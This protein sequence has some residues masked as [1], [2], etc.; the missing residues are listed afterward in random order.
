MR[1]FTERAVT[2]ALFLIATLD[3]GAATIINSPVDIRAGIVTGTKLSNPLVYTGAASISTS[4]LRTITGFRQ[5]E[6]ADFTVVTVPDTGA[7][8]DDGRLDDMMDWVVA[9]KTVL[10]IKAVLGLGDITPVH[11]P[12]SFANGA[13]AYSVAMAAGLPIL[14]I[15]GN[16]DSWNY[17]DWAEYDAEF[18]PAYF[19]GKSW[20]GG[21]NGGSDH[22]FYVTFT[23]G[24]HNYLVIGLGW[25]ILPADIVW[26][27]GIVNNNPT[28]EIIVATHAY[29]NAD[30]ARSKLGDTYTQGDD[31]QGLWDSFVKLNPEIFLVVNGHFIDGP[32]SAHMTDIG[33]GGNLV[34]QL[35]C[36]YQDDGGGGSEILQLLT[37]QPATGNI[38]VSFWSAITDLEVGTPFDLKY[39]TPVA[40]TSLAATG[41]LDVLG[42]S[43]LKGEA[44][45]GD[46]IRIQSPNAEAVWESAV[47]KYSDIH[48]NAAGALAIDAG[49]TNPIRLNPYHGG[50]VGIGPTAPLGYLDLN[51]PFTGPDYGYGLRNIAVVTAPTEHTFGFQNMP[52]LVNETTGKWAYGAKLGADVQPATGVTLAGA[53]GVFIPVITENGAGTVTDAYGLYVSKPTAGASHN[54]GAYIA[55]PVGIGTTAPVIGDDSYKTPLVISS[56]EAAGTFVAIK[57][58]DAT[59]G[60]GGIWLQANATN[61]GWLFGTQNDGS[62]VLHYGSGASE[63]AA[64]TAAKSAT[65]LGLTI[66][67]TGEGGFGTTAPIAGSPLTLNTAE[68]Y[69]SG[70]QK[71]LVLQNS[72]TGNNANDYPGLFFRHNDTG[73]SFA[74]YPAAIIASKWTNAT[75]FSGGLLFQTK[76]SDNSQ[77]AQPTTKATLLASGNFG[78][79]IAAPLSTLESG[80]SFGVK[81]TTITYATPTYTIADEAILIVDTTGGN[82]TVTLPSAA[83]VLNRVYEIDKSV[84]ANT[85]TIQPNAADGIQGLA[86]N[87]PIALKSLNEGVQIVAVT[88][89]WRLRETGT[90]FR[91]GDI[92][93]WSGAVANMQW[94]WQLCDGTN[95]TYNLTDK[96][97]IGAGSTYTVG[98]SVGSATHTHAIPSTDS[99]GSHTHTYIAGPF[100]TSTPF[101]GGAGVAAGTDYVVTDTT[102]IHFVSVGGTT[103]SGG[104]HS[105]SITAAS[106]SGS[107]LPPSYALCYIVRVR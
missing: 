95:D 29:L 75:N 7:E 90:G 65:G 30:G 106:G 8:C 31:G 44:L 89:G 9:N 40:D 20:Y 38:H 47:N 19:A 21:N 105:H 28:K 97:I 48:K 58:T 15:G 33:D 68:A 35:F 26:A 34:H 16:H 56:S 103:D 43:R 81:V 18:G 80:G 45:I 27:Q 85:L 11:A 49:G 17:V 41:D 102:H 62:A 76:A 10:N 63:T 22:D 107:S 70:I 4:R 79:M 59:Y 98:Q 74:W 37:F 69:N 61:A 84:A 67:T 88:E 100:A 25:W 6:E 57:N 82:I 91:V 87:T 104:S 93:V 71:T 96:F 86:D 14:P 39:A 32:H 72:P 64:L 101:S 50:N 83:T 46:S 99:G 3:A 24:T 92:K 78:V 60:Y 73:N 51:G 42:E 5:S 55:D 77:S 36:N 23:V 13:A 2:V 1:T 54:Y 12:A 94:N 66:A 52:T 53:A